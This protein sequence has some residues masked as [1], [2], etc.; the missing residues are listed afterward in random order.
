MV[1]RGSTAKRGVE[2][3]RGRRDGNGAAAACAA[4]SADTNKRERG[5]R[6]SA[7]RAGDETGRLVHRQ[8]RHQFAVVVA[9]FLRQV[10]LH[11]AVL[12]VEVLALGAVVDGDLFQAERAR[13]VVLVLSKRRLGRVMIEVSDCTPS[14]HHKHGSQTAFQ[15][16]HPGRADDH[17]P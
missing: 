10:R 17:P 3:Q 8:L 5:R 6:I 1:F 4:T 7:Y 14:S 2:E 16:K 13:H 9:P 12:A 11:L 15:R